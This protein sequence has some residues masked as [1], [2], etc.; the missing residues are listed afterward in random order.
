GVGQLTFQAEREGYYRLA[1]QSSQGTH[2]S[3]SK[4][5]RTLPPIKAESYVFVASNTS[6]DLGYRQQGVEIVV[7]KDTVRAGQTTPVMLLVPEA[8]RYVLFSVEADDLYSY[9]VV[10][11]TGTAK[12]IELPIDERHVPNVYL[13]ATMI[14]NAQMFAATKQLV[15]PPVKQFLTVDVK[16]D[17]EQYQPREEGT[18]WITTKDVDGRPVAAEVALGLIDESVKYIQKDFAGDPRQFYYGAKRTLQVQTQS[19]FHQKSY[20]RLVEVEKG[21]L[22][23]RKD[24]DDREVMNAERRGAYASGTAGAMGRGDLAAMSPGTVAE[25]VSVDGVSA[26]AISNLPLNAREENA[27]A[28]LIHWLT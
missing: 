18:L 16:S 2:V 14:S 9:Q 28:R 5:V 3:A 25:S 17:R 27:F 22:I 7:D 12:L 10:H 11:V 26:K 6:N 21:Q 24:S 19:T 20:A 13:N 4:R 8:D 1:W 23:D 15:V